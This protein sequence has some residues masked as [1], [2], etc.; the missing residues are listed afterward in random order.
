[1][2]KLTQAEAQSVL[3]RV[4]DA[5]ARSNNVEDQYDRG[6]ALDRIDRMMEASAMYVFVDDAANASSCLIVS[7]SDGILTPLATAHVLLMWFAEDLP[8][9]RQSILE[10]Q[11]FQTLFECAKD[12]SCDILS[13]SSWVFLGAEDVSHT[14]L[15]RGFDLCAKTFTMRLETE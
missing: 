6:H 15:N 8:K 13:G 4:L 7:V 2:K 12:E 5:A 9:E 14:W 11:A 3:P 10:E 1:M